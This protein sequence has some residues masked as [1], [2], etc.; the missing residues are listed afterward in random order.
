MRRLSDPVHYPTE[1]LPESLTV[2]GERVRRLVAPNPGL[3]T[4]PGTNTYVLGAERFL[5]IDPGPD[6]PGHVARLLEVTQ[7]RVDAVLVTHTHRDHSPAAATLAAATGAVRLGRPAPD[8]T[9][10]DRSFVPTRLLADGDFVAS[11]AG[12]L[13][14]LHTPGHASNHLCFLLEE[15]SLLFTGDHLVQGGTVVIPP[16]DGHMG[17][18]LR[19]LERLLEEPVRRLA[20]GHGAVIPDAHAEIRRVHTHRLARESKLLERLEMLGAC[21]LDRLVSSV[22][23]DV[24]PTLHRW[25]RHSLLA[26]LIKLEEEGRV[27]RAS[28]RWQLARERE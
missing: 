11:E 20:P 16:P 10:Q 6:D 3:M 21:E 18:Y 15:Q 28:D 27:Q 9:L 25:A 7:G 5:V 24:L 8:D 2:V 13:R 1:L 14:V 23:D 26:H 22:Y 19:S 12:N 4:G 17:D